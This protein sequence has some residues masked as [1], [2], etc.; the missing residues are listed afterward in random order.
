MFATNRRFLVLE[1]SGDPFAPL[2]NQKHPEEE[3]EEIDEDAVE[4]QQRDLSESQLKM[5]FVTL[6]ADNLLVR[7]DPVGNASTPQQASL[8][9]IDSS[10][11]RVKTQIDDAGSVEKQGKGKAKAKS[12][13][14]A[15]SSAAS[16]KRASSSST[17]VDHALMVNGCMNGWVIVW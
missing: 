1:V 9:A 11:E 16:R 10:N 5:E 12:K 3:E 6:V 14:K 13:S 7:V 8:S 4:A 17:G 15:K 2:E